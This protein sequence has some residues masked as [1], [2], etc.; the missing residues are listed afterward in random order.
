MWEGIPIGGVPLMYLVL[1]GICEWAYA[2]RSE[3]VRTK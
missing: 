2:M 3:P 1:D